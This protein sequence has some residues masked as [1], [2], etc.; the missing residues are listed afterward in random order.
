MAP[1]GKVEPA[2]LK[3][4]V[5]SH[6]SEDEDRVKSIFTK[7]FS[8][9][10]IVREDLYGHYKNRIVKFSY[11]SK[12]REE[13]ERILKAIPKDIVPQVE[14]KR[15]FYRIS[16]NALAREGVFKEPESELDGAIAIEVS[17]S[18]FGSGNIEEWIESL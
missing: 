17:F 10:E 6:L 18:V 1:Y 8:E 7:L 11:S 3:A 9:T 12:R 2:L 5:F 15:A 14:E 4:N 13:I 16:K